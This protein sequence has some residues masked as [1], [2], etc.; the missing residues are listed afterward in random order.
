MATSPP[1]RIRVL[2]VT[3]NLGIGGAER[4]I[5]TLA[6]ALDPARF[7]ARVVCIKEEGTLFDDVVRAGVPALSLGAGT[8]QAPAT[9]VRLVRIMRR[10]RPDAV[11]TRGLNADILG[12]TAATIARVPAV[13]LWK[14]NTGH[15]ERSALEVVSERLLDPVTDRYFAVAHG[16]VP[17]LTGE[18]GWP[19]RKIRVIHNGVDPGAFPYRAPGGERPAAAAGLGIRPGDRAVGILAVFRPEKDHATFIR[20]ARIVADRIPEARFVLAGDGPGREELEALTRE[21]GLEDGVVFAGLRSDVEDVLA[22]LDVVVLSSFTIECFPYAI[23]EAMAMGVPAVCTAVG[24]L[25]EMIED[26]VTGRLVPPKDPAA[27]AEGIIDVL[28]DEGRRRA[29]GVAA[30][31]RLEANFTLERSAA[32]AGDMIAEAIA[33]PS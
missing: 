12:R 23:L 18:L 9:L 27:L 2:F 28:S 1:D 21:L 11:I 6:P 10:F 29:M 22:S 8:R 15:I 30:R 16:Q 3:P 13:I 17:Y 4:H 26:G 25:P 7:E 14:H 19:E 31:E 5:A 33:S 24:G 20:A 32:A